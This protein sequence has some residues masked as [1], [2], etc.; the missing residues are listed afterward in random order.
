MAQSSRA[1]K[2]ID[3][4]CYSADAQTRPFSL[5]WV[6]MGLG[7]LVVFSSVRELEGGLII[8]PCIPGGDA[9]S[10]YLD[11]AMSKKRGT[12]SIRASTGGGV[13]N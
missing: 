3:C 8:T 11:S 9:L 13:M 4:A 10:G 5:L 2:N 6:S 12:S 1:G 7:I